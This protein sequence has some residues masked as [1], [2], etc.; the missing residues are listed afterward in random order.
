MRVCKLSIVLPLYPACGHT[1]VLPATY[2]M[3]GKLLHFIF[4]FF[5]KYFDL[6]DG[7]VKDRQEKGKRNSMDDK[8]QRA[9]GSGKV[10]PESTFGETH[11]D[12]TL[13][14]PTT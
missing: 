6:L 2:S 4:L 14:W 8:S 12:V 3:S 1:N 5:F 10:E 13:G 9:T 7:I 11:L